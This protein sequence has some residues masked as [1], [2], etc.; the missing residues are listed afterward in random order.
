[1]PITNYTYKTKEGLLDM[2]RILFKREHLQLT[3]L[4][5]PSS[6]ELNVVDDQKS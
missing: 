6:F 3:I 4:L 1:M 2:V 5:T